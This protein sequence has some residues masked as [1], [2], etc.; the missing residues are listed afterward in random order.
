MSSPL[1]ARGGSCRTAGVLEKQ[2]YPGSAQILIVDDDPVTCRLLSQRVQLW[3]P[4][5]AVEISGRADEALSRIALTDYDAIVS[6]IKMPGM[7]GLELLSAIRSLRPDTPTL[8]ITGLGEH[9]LVV[10]ALRRGAYDF[11][12]KPIEG[13]YF[14][15]ALKR[16]LNAR[17]LAR[18]VRDQQEALATRNLALEKTQEDLRALAA[19][20]ITVQEEERRRLSR[21]LHDD[22]GQRL[23]VVRMDLDALQKQLSAF[24]GEIRGRLQ[25]VRKQIT[26][27]SD[28]IRQLAAQLH[29]SVL[30]HFG[31]AVA[32][33][34]Y[35]KDFEKREGIRAHFSC[36]DLPDRFP[37]ETASCLYRIVQEALRN[38]SRHARASHV[39]VRLKRSAN[40]LHLSIRD[41]GV[42]FDMEALKGRRGLGL[43]SMQERVRLVHGRFRVRSRLGS[44]T[45]LFVRV[46]LPASS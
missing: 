7:D 33:D 37:K 22:V 25:S 46:P 12:A 28:D 15:A 2:A 31:L 5:V 42:G 19:Q 36:R 17:R 29:P 10:Q 41:D 30:D 38:V 8:I 26:D 34:A 14:I 9:E 45:H 39:V 23:A 32:V 4:A 35:V 11:I 1:Q 3:M 18:Q 40:F 27:L 44:G 13:D 16:A 24:S 43:V 6:D 20:L 21:E